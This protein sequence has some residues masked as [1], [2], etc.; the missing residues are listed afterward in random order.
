MRFSNDSPMSEGHRALGLDDFDAPRLMSCLPSCILQDGSTRLPSCLFNLARRSACRLP[1]AVEFALRGCA[2]EHRFAAPIAP[3]PASD[4]LLHVLCS[5]YFPV[6]CRPCIDP[7]RVSPLLAAS[8]WDS[9]AASI[10][11]SVC[12]MALR[13]CRRQASDAPWSPARAL[14]TARAAVDAVG[15][16]AGEAFASSIVSLAAERRLPPGWPRRSQSTFTSAVRRHGI[17]HGE[18]MWGAL[19]VYVASNDPW[20]WTYCTVL[21]GMRESYFAA[22]VAREQH[23]TLSPPR[24]TRR[25]HV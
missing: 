5:P 12:A 9:T 16:A 24:G 4:T 10:A 22:R 18:S 11:V 2:H 1:R 25:L 21:Y 20:R 14:A 19:G 6:A 8:T 3:P 13:P 17:S 7:R 15:R 23:L